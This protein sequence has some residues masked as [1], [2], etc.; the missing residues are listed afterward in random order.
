MDNAKEKIQTSAGYLADLCLEDHETYHNYND[1]GLVNA[2]LV[3]SHFLMDHIYAKSQH[4]PLKKQEELAQTVGEAIRELI[5][6]ST[7]K[8]MHNLVKKLYGQNNKK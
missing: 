1:E 6:A 7:G 2:T 8:D 5:K 3:F 4:L